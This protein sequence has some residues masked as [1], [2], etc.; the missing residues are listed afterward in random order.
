[1]GGGGLKGVLKMGFGIPILFPDHIIYKD[2]YSEEAGAALTSPF[3]GLCCDFSNTTTASNY[4][5]H[6]GI[7][8]AIYGCLL[9]VERCF[10]Q[11]CDKSSGIRCKDAIP[12]AGL[13]LRGT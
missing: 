2:P 11:T 5:N 6:P 13:R 8:C 4:P 7:I 12:P 3:Q 9:R 1:M 10:G